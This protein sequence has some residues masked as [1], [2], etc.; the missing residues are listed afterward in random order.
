MSSLFQRPYRERKEHPVRRLVWCGINLFV[1]P[2][3]TNRMRMRLLRWFG[4]K[5]DAY[6]VVNPSVRIFAP[7]NLEVKA[8]W[9]VLAP[10]VEVYNKAKVTLGSHAIVSQGAY[11]CTASHDVSSPVMELVTKPIVLGDDTW[12]AAKAVVLPGVTLHEGAVVG[13]AAVV[14]KDVEPWTVV[15]GNPA[16]FIKKRVLKES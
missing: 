5:I 13:C 10:H 14:T 12:V 4:A 8:P 1:F 16:K 15:G 9:A 3:V 11:L 6:L 2:L 7:W